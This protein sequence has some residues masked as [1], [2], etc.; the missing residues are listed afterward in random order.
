MFSTNGE[1]IC[2]SNDLIL[3]NLTL[4]IE[5][6][7]TQFSAGTFLFLLQ[8]QISHKWRTDIVTEVDLNLLKNASKNISLIMPFK[9]YFYS[10][11]YSFVDYL[12]GKAKF[13][14]QMNRKHI[15]III[16]DN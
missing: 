7:K 8:G 2:S 5:V 6:I 11:Y 15:I 10:K 1:D 9:I 14:I 3:I 4:V 13:I 12:A 16:I